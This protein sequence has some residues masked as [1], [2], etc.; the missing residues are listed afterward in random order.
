MKISCDW[1]RDADVLYVK[2]TDGT[3]SI[4]GL[5]IINISAYYDTHNQKD[6]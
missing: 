4:V 5:Q 1:N 3:Y 2:F 6:K